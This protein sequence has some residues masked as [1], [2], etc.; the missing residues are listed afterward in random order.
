MSRKL[1]SFFTFLVVSFSVLQLAICTPIPQKTSSDEVQDTR[2]IVNKKEK[3]KEA[4]KNNVEE[5]NSDVGEAVIDILG[6]V[7]N[8]VNG[9]LDAAEEIAGNEEVQESVSNIVDVGLK[10][11]TQAALAGAQVAEAAPS[12]FEEKGNF[13]AG[14]TK[15]VEETGGLLTGSIDELEQGAKLFSV[16]AQAYTDITL[17]RIEN[18][19]KTFNKRFKCNTDCRKLKDG[20]PEKVQCEKDYCEGFV[21][22][23]TKEQQEEEELKKL[24]EQYDYDYSDEDYEEEDS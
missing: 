7:L 24:A 4:N 11:G 5:E 12:H 8:L 22:P 9:A 2:D 20:T 15:T 3:K 21:K 6:G 14:L 17:K 16:F 1:L 13:A 10:S 19:S 23:K 18:F